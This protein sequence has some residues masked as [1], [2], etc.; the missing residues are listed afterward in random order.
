MRYLIRGP[1][2]FLQK[3]EIAKLLHSTKNNVPGKNLIAFV[4]RI[5]GELFIISC[6][7]FSSLTSS[8]LKP[9]ISLT[10]GTDD[11]SFTLR[12]TNILN[13]NRDVI[14][15]C[16]ITDLQETARY[17]E[18]LVHKYHLLLRSR[19]RLIDRLLLLLHPFYWS[20]SNDFIYFV[21]ISLLTYTPTV[22]VDFWQYHCSY[23]V[24][25]FVG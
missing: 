10:S 24:P 7:I 18:W 23:G 6:F 15:N 22:S 17:L 13:G 11:A 25:F 1:V 2:P 3:T 14:G 9:L 12:S 19:C 5:S 20:I 4:S 21:T 16:C 8:F